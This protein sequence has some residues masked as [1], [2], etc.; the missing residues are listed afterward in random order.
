MIIILARRVVIFQPLP[1]N[2]DS[3]SLGGPP[4]GL[5]SRQIYQ[6]RFGLSRELLLSMNQGVLI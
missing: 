6:S 3:Q 1:P 5:P 4:S 2:S